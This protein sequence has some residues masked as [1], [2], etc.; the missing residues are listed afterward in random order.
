MLC[1][2]LGFH[3]SDYEECRLL[4]Y[5]NPVRTSQRTHY[6][7]ATEPSPLMLC[8]FWGFHGGDYEECGLLG[9]EALWF[10]YTL[11]KGAIGSPK[12]RFSQEPHCKMFRA[13]THSCKQS[14]RLLQALKQSLSSSIRHDFKALYYLMMSRSDEGGIYEDIPAEHGWMQLW[15]IS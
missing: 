6:I 10:F 9:C 3:G 2:I 5:K 12:H 1:K 4:G 13:W 15:W 8:K 11:K 14:F 7:S